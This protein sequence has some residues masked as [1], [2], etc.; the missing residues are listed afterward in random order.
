MNVA[1][2]F[3]NEDDG[4]KSKRMKEIVEQLFKVWVNTGMSLKMEYKIPQKTQNV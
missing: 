4:F 3:L 1:F 2:S